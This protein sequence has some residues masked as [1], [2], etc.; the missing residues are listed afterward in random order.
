MGGGVG[1]GVGGCVGNGVGGTVGV[2]S[3]K[4]VPGWV[5]VHPLPTVLQQNA[6][7]STDQP[8][9]HLA[10][11]ASQS[12]NKVVTSPHNQKSKGINSNKLRRQ[13]VVMRQVKS[14]LGGE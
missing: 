5:V 3:G 9:S 4:A 1:G 10:K 6:C 11:P 7:F 2:V 14:L 8:D 12:N 13:Q